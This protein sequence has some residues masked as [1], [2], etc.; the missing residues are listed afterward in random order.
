MT[1][2]VQHNRDQSEKGAFTV[3]FAVAGL[4]LMGITALALETG[5]MM[6]TK[7]ELQ[8]VADVA[9]ASANLELGRIYADAGNVDISDYQ[10]TGDDRARIFFAANRFSLKNEAA[11]KHIWIHPDDFKFGTWDKDARE[12]IPNTYGVTSVSISARRDAYA[13]G[14]VSTLMASVAG[15]NEFGAKVDAVG[16]VSP[17]RKLPAGKGDFPV[18][19]AS[20]WF[21]NKDSPCGPDSSITFYPTGTLEGCAGWHTFEDEPANAEKLKSILTG[22][23]NGTWES[24]ELV[25]G[26]TYY[27]FTGGTVGSALQRAKEAYDSNKDADGKWLVHIP[28]FEATDCANPTGWIKIIG[29]ATALIDNVV[30]TGQKVIEGEIQ[31]DVVMYGKGGGPDY[32][33]SVGMGQLVN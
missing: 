32:G 23:E 11:G 13:N 9:A 3:L 24:P 31:C 20:F 25:T 21:Q 2:P 10:L 14:K 30:A 27:N 12:L 29:V 6:V 8:N 28:V 7:A 19:I 5:Y 18:G 15:L 16:R 4:G 33:T 22:I 17:L 1:H 26:E